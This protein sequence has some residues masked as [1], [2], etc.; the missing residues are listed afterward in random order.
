MS[1]RGKVAY[2]PGD[3]RVLELDRVL[4]EETPHFGLWLDSSDQTVEETFD[5]P[6]ATHHWAGWM[7]TVAG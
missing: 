1:S 6:A 7:N 5:E 4:R 2:K 3:R